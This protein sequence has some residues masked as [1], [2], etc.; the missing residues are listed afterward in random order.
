MTA[1]RVFVMLA[2]EP[3]LGA[4]AYPIGAFGV[5]AAGSMDGLGRP[6]VSW[7]PMTY[8]RGL[9]WRRRLAA[10]ITD[11]L[12]GEWLD[13]GQLAEVPVQGSASAQTT[14]ADTVEMLLDGI[15]LKVLPAFCER[16]VE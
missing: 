2:W 4:Y 7:V 11:E 6:Y 3:T 5:T 8:E 1:R 10:P 13:R 15:L 9:V 16:R 14:V 12:T